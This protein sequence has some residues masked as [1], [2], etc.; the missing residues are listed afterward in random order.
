MGMGMTT[1]STSVTILGAVTTDGTITFPVEKIGQTIVQFAN[2]GTYNDGN[3]IRTNTAGKTLY[4][5]SLSWSVN[6]GAG[7]SQSGIRD[8][9]TIIWISGQLPSGYQDTITVT[10]PTPLK[11]THSVVA[12]GILHGVSFS[13]WEQ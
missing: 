2:S 1:T 9:A 12:S 3:L 10:F 4:I 5:S 13:G 8:N 7:G 11:V 6:Y